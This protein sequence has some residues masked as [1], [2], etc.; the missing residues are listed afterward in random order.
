MKPTQQ[1][2]TDHQLTIMEKVRIN[3]LHTTWNNLP[4]P[5]IPLILTLIVLLIYTDDDKTSLDKWKEYKGA[6]KT[7][8]K[9]S[10]PGMNISKYIS[11]LLSE[12]FKIKIK[13]ERHFTN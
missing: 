2:V 8:S 6:S 12:N 11:L 3:K 13:S 4:V 1:R 7:S 10:R 5:I 9:K